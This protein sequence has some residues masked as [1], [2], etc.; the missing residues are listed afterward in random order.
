MA[1]LLVD[2]FKPG[3]ILRR[4]KYRLTLA[5]NRNFVKHQTSDPTFIGKKQKL[6]AKGAFEGFYSSERARLAMAIR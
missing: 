5:E 4:L 6:P 1:N 2:V 3:G